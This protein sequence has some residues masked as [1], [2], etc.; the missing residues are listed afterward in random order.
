MRTPTARHLL[1]IA[2]FAV[3]LFA[4]GQASAEDAKATATANA[5]LADSGSYI[6]P[7]TAPQAT[8]VV[9]KSA[10][11][12]P[13]PAKATAPTNTKPAHA[14]A[15]PHAKIPAKAHAKP[16]PTTHAKTTPPKQDKG[17]RKI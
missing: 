12:T 2:T 7:K 13:A 5:L 11:A 16:S 1:A 9:G 10:P 8:P 3:A 14:K 4:V 17:A 15:K 6:P